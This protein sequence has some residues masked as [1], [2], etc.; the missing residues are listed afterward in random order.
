LIPPLIKGG[1]AL[2]LRADDRRRHFDPTKSS[3]LHDHQPGAIAIENAPVSNHSEDRRA[4]RYLNESGSQISANL[5]AEQIYTAVHRA[6]ERVMPADT[7]VITLWDETT[8][9]IEGVYLV[10]KGKRLAPTRAPKGESLSGR[11]IETGQPV[12][13]HVLEESS[14]AGGYLYGA[15]ENP[16]S[17]L[18]VP[19]TLAAAVGVVR[20]LRAEHL[21]RAGP[22][23]GHAGEPG[24]SSHSFAACSR[25]RS[26]G[27]RTARGRSHGPAAA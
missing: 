2:R 9:E 19:M 14:Q 27:A 21:H 26:D 25:T 16:R 1:T 13:T 18:A 7:F 23:P 8:D 11:I 10:D 20:R 6:A 3:C 15:T 17:I 5:D 24:H 12:L 22:D 4:L